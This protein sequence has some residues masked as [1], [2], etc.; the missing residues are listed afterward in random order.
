KIIDSQSIKIQSLEKEKEAEIGER[1]RQIKALQ[2]QVNSREQIIADLERARKQTIQQAQNS[3]SNINTQVTKLQNQVQKVQQERE[4]T[5][6]RLQNEINTL[7]E[8][9][10]SFTSEI[11]NKNNEI[12]KMSN[13]INREK[14]QLESRFNAELT[15]KQ[16]EIETLNVQMK[17]IEQQLNQTRTK[18]SAIPVSIPSENNNIQMSG[19]Q[20]QLQNKKKEIIVLQKQVSEHPREIQI[21]EQKIQRL[22]ANIL[23]L[24]RES[25]TASGFAQ[26]AAE[27]QQTINQLERQVTEFQQQAANRLQNISSSETEMKKLQTQINNLKIEK[28]TKD[29]EILSLKTRLDSETKKLQSQILI[30]EKEVETLNNRISEIQRAVSSGNVPNLSDDL[31]RAENILGQ[32]QNSVLN[33]QSKLEIKTK[34]LENL[35]DANSRIQ[36]EFKK[37]IL[38]KDTDIQHLNKMIT[39]MNAANLS[40]KKQEKQA[41]KILETN[42]INI[43]QKL[44]QEINILKN[45]IKEQRTTENKE[46]N[47]VAKKEKEIQ[48]LKSEIQRLNGKD[49][50]TNN[51]IS[52]KSNEIN[53][54]R[55]QVQTSGKQQELIVR[56]KQ[57]E[58]ILSEKEKQIS[59]LENEFE[60]VQEVVRSGTVPVASSN[61]QSVNSNLLIL[62]KQINEKNSK[63][64]QLEEAAKT[65]LKAGETQV[66]I[67]NDKA[68]QLQKELEH[69]DRKAQQQIETGT[70][71]INQMN[72][73]MSGIK[74]QLESVLKTVEREKANTQEKIAIKNTRIQALEEDVKKLSEIKPGQ[75]VETG[76][77]KKIVEQKDALISNLE[78][79]LREKE[80]NVSDAKSELAKLNQQM[81]DEIIRFEK[82]ISEKEEQIQRFQKATT[83]L[84]ELEARVNAQLKTIEMRNK[85]KQEQLITIETLNVELK[86]L[87]E[88]AK[89]ANQLQGSIDK[90]SKD[91]KTEKSKTKDLQMELKRVRDSTSDEIEKRSREALERIRK[92]EMEKKAAEESALAEEKLKE[93][94]EKALGMCEKELE[95]LQKEIREL[96]ELEKGTR[97]TIQNLTKIIN[98]GGLDNVRN[99]TVRKRV[100]SKNKYVAER[101]SLDSFREIAV[102]TNNLKSPESCNDIVSILKTVRQNKKEIQ[103]IARDVQNDWEDVRGIG[104]VYLRMKGETPETNSKEKYVKADGREIVIRDVGRCNVREEIGGDRFGP[105]TGVFN[106]TTSNKIIFDNEIA[107]TIKNISTGYRIVIFTY[108]QTSAGKCQARD[109]PVFMANGTIKMVQNIHTGEE[110]MG[111]DSAPRKILSTTIGNGEMFEISGKYKED[112]YTVNSD[113]ILCLYNG[114]NLI[115]D[116]PERHSFQVTVYDV[117]K[118]DTLDEGST[119]KQYSKSFSY[120]NRDKEKVQHEAYNFFKETNR[121]ER[122]VTISVKNYLKL[123]VNF[124]KNLK[125]YRTELQFPEK[126]IEIDPYI[127][128]VWLG[129]GTSTTSAVTKQDSAILKYLAENLPEIGCY[130]SFQQSSDYAYRINTTESKNAFMTFLKKNNLIGNKHIPEI[131][132]LNSRGN[133]LKLLAGLIDTDGNYNKKFTFEIIQKSNNLSED[134][135]FLAKSLGFEVYTRK[136]NKSCMVNGE[137]FTGEYNRISI[138][139]DNLYEI[140][141]LC[142]RK[143]ITQQETNNRSSLRQGIFNTYRINV[144]SVGNDDYYGFMTDGN[145]KY[146]LGN[147]IVTHNSFTL[148]GSGAQN[149]GIAQRSLDVLVKLA[150]AGAVEQIDISARQIY[151][152]A[153]YDVFKTNKLDAVRGSK[154]TREQKIFNLGDAAKLRSAK[155]ISTVIRIFQAGDTSVSLQNSFAK[156][157]RTIQA[158]RPTRQTD[159]NPESSRSHLFV[160]LTITFTD[161]LAKQI[162]RKTTQLTFVDV[163]GNEQFAAATSQSLEEGRAINTTLKVMIDSL[164]AYAEGKDINP[165]QARIMSDLVKDVI[166][167]NET[168]L[169]TKV[170][171]FLNIHTFFMKESGTSR[172]IETK[173]NVNNRI[174]TTTADTLN[175]GQILMSLDQKA[176]PR[177]T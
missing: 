117:S 115:R 6:S 157:F 171:M 161:K 173:E 122:K 87:R 139:G 36:N 89:T 52:E 67:T 65:V 25:K 54:L 124:R 169:L 81:K 3:S 40:D 123:P 112:R 77:D 142:P 49:Q 106:E 167:F 35:E 14:Q 86:Q 75:I 97:N 58:I 12:S 170:I 84:I 24:E 113:H 109:T 48:Q 26:N 2:M 141:I 132:K 72:A 135:V 30:E 127:L 56:I 96:S 114:N 126:K 101:K 70:K 15:H 149:K 33:L 32:T 160:T 164:T 19:L 134:I 74:Q 176:R 175:I 10:N 172:Q 8:K 99:S 55:L 165:G 64:R 163:A 11:K 146:V 68:T 39:E 7:R 45:Q 94:E 104:R 137:K 21:A 128:G 44:N 136:V 1:N 78:R 159:A 100:S 85:E 63:I 47:A 79:Q 83:R 110:I 158:R 177:I 93:E 108:G 29:Q 51:K 145:H 34:A 147:F 38:K 50:E 53:T 105:F 148:L 130:L 150:N 118:N 107:D 5:I 102:K 138:G 91:L 41:A 92:L 103:D 166:D 66:R 76:I 98:R 57:L 152:M 111:D 133:R 69:Q 22:E 18:L 46:E 151:K 140:P 144:E 28:N 131:Y 59:E 43:I 121:G 37:Q 60:K 143:Q 162:G 174:C 153:L 116:R 9:T 119:F 156:Q 71:K 17:T 95:I 80:K 154:P 155:D 16:Q 27:F 20:Q 82:E 88:G 42:E 129:D 23:S 73:E 62:Q 90:M 61:P 168:K 31:R 13:V 120:G 125:G 4:Q